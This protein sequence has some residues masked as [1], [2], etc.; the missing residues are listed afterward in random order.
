MQ[1]TFSCAVHVELVTSARP[2]IPFEALFDHCRQFPAT[3]CG[4]PSEAVS[5]QTSLPEWK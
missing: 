5:V 2:L 3:F 1:G 4:W